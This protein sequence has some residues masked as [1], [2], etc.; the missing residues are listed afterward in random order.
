MSEKDRV[1]EAD[2]S[3]GLAPEKAQ[4]LLDSRAQRLSRAMVSPVAAEDRVTLME[5][6]LGTDTYGVDPRLVHHVQLVPEL[7]PLPHMESH[8]AGILNLRGSVLLVAHLRPLLGLPVKAG[9]EATRLIVVGEGEPDL[10]L[11]VDDVLGVVEHNR[12][13]FIEGGTVLP[14]F[15]PEFVLGVVRSGCVMLNLI[16]L[17][18]D[19]RL[20]VDV[21]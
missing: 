10:G 15:A 6:K 11:L 5:F 8:I 13:E 7:S 9:D 19:S 20:T 4:A 14:A 2:Q 12:T 1:P 18:K 17:L 16:N 21:A 3:L